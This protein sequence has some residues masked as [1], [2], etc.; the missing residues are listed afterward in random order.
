MDETTHLQVTEVAH[1]HAHEC[2]CG[3]DDSLPE[4]DARVIPHAIRHAAIFGALGAVKPGGAMVLVAPH[5]PKP[6][7]AQLAQREGD[8]V[9]V[10]YLEEGPEAWRLK[11]TR[12]S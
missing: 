9:A 6:L 8:A 11:F 1:A 2:A 4:L 12:R 3:A 7:L 10:S 5:D